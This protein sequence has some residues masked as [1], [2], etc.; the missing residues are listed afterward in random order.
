MKLIKKYTIFIIGLMFFGFGIS[1]G[2][3]SQ[4]GNNPMGV[5]VTGLAIQL[6]FSV[7]TC[8]MLLGL[9]ETIAGYFLDKKNISIATFLVVFCGSYSIDLGNYLIPDTSNAII[10]IIYMLFGIIF[11]CL[12][13]SIQQ[14]AKCG[15]SNYDCFVFGISKKLNIKDY[16]KIRRVCDLLFII[17]GYLLGGIVGIGTIILVLFSGKIII[18]F[19]KIITKLFVNTNLC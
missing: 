19:K 10:K 6:G 9:F 7:G 1:F 14:Y 8:N 4:L 3:K 18:C 5:F 15:L 12:G 2:I 13:F 11:Y 16:A 17:L